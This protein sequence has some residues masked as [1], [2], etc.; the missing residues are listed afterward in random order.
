MTLLIICITLIAIAWM[1]KPE[2]GCDPQVY[3]E[4]MNGTR[5]LGSAYDIHGK[6]IRNK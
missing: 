4:F 1:L 3:E 6:P 2:S 5:G